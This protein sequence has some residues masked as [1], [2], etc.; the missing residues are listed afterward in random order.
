MDLDKF[1]LDHLYQACPLQL[2]QTAFKQSEGDLLLLT[3][4]V[5]LCF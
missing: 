5:G 3:F 4:I 2:V 1:N